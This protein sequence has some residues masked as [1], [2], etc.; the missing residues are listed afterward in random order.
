MFV[1]WSQGN[2]IE[3][4]GEVLATVTWNGQDDTYV[5]RYWF[6]PDGDQPRKPYTLIEKD[7]AETSTKPRGF[8]R[9]DY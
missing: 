2:G 5:V 1:T 9:A 6:D 4:H 7:R 8:I 3:C